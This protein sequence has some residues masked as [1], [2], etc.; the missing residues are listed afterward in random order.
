MLLWGDA[1]PFFPLDL[2]RRLQEAFLDAALVEI[3]GGRLFFPL[4]EPQRVADAI[5]TAFHPH[6]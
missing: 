3:P 5:S 2:A 6:R 4:D 1:D